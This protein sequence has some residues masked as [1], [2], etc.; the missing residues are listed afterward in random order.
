MN[1][2]ITGVAGFIGFHVARRLLR[3][4]WQ[5]QGLDSLNDY[6]DPALKRARLALLESDPGFRFV[7]ADLADRVAMEALFADH[8]FD[9]VIHLAAQAGVRYS[10]ENPHAYVDA[11]LA[12]LLNVLEGC[13]AQQVA[14][15]VYASSSSVYGLNTRV[16]FAE[17][18]AVDHP[19]SLYAATKKSGELLA[20]SYSHLY[21]LP[22]TGLRFFTVYGPWGRPDMAP[23]K[24]ARAICAGEAIDI[25]NQGDMSR[26]F[27]Y[28]DDIVEGVVRVLDQ[29]PGM[30]PG[31][32]P[33]Q[34][35][36][37]Q[38]SAPYRIFNIGAGQPV[39]LLDFVR[40]LE[41]AL[42][43]PARKNFLPMQPGDVARTW[44]ST[45]ALRNQTGFSPAVGLEE[46][47]ERFVHWFRGYY[48]VR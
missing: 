4:G 35:S 17:S 44:A 9:R 29:I 43:V 46:G 38:S 48:G 1:V 10:L 16:P 28:I 24:F 37:G 39:G 41:T 22:A 2:L 14:H 42:G 47:V 40:T 45:E 23:I 15:L 3:A 8:A 26:D 30:Q 25:Y 12:G 5:V 13:R 34:G 32:T 18:D 7:N 11:N 6:Y 27:T 20:H 19:V 33:E 31:W 36:R 21:G